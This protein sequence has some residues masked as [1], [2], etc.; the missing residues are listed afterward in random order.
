MTPI[1]KAAL[2]TAL[3]LFS[4]WSAPA[5]AQS[6]AGGDPCARSEAV[7]R[8][9]RNFRVVI[10]HDTAIDIVK[11]TQKACALIADL[12]RDNPKRDDPKLAD[13]LNGVIEKLNAE[14]LDDIY[15]EYPDLRGKDL[16]AIQSATT[17]SPETEKQRIDSLPPKMGPSTATYLRWT[18]GNIQDLFSNAIG[19]KFCLHA[20]A[21][22]CIRPILDIIA[23]LG[24]AEDPVYKGFPDLWRLTAKEGS[25]RAEAQP[26]TAE[27]DAQLRKAQP[28]VGSVKL[29]A[30]AVTQIRD[31]L[32][33]VRRDGG[34]SCQ[35]VS[36][37]WNIGSE[38]KGPNDSAWTKLPP[39]V[40]IGA[41]GCGEI[42]ADIIQT[43]DGVRIVFGSDTAARFE[44]KLVDFDGKR[45]TLQDQ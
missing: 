42:P 14:V 34:R 20:Q 41:Y 11:H 26:R 33:S 8:S 45:F 7:S 4:L 32:A 37:A 38:W 10:E 25:A 28:K 6:A 29:S 9:P 39:G 30:A 22:T 35:I 2:R 40:G 24:F 31:F 15:R 5:I 23:E 19:R 12:I 18:F 16:R 1:R 3:V 21:Y 27:S 13:A 44:G 17:N 36:I 43:I